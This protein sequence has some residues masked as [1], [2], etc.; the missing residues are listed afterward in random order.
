MIVRAVAIAVLLL[1]LPAAANE[2]F[3]TLHVVDLAAR[4][5]SST[6]PLVFDANVESTRTF[7]GVVPHARL[8]SP[9]EDPVPRLPADKSTPL[10]FYCANTYCTASH[11][12]ADKAIDAGYKNVG[13]MVDGIY[14]WRDAKQ[15]LQKIPPEPAPMPPPDVLSLQR[16]QTAVIVDVREGEE[17]HEIVDGAQWMPMTTV[18]DTKKW[19]AFERSLP[20]DKTVVVY[21]AMGVRA[22]KVAEMLREDGFTT[23]FFDGPDQWKAAGLSVKP[24]PAR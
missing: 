4:L 3:T 14:G 9:G 19:A 11:Q 21:C 7:V 13:V 6:P 18:S 24:G 23:A 5:A 15:P 1:S 20:R 16:K 2:R 12:A 17:R 10:V 22:K 8:L